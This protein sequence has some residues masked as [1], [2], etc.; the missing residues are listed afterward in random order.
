MVEPGVDRTDG[1]RWIGP[2]PGGVPLP[3]T[4]PGAE[5]PAVTL[6]RHEARRLRYFRDL[7]A[8]GYRHALAPDPQSRS[9]R[10]E[11]I[12][13]GIDLP[14]L[15]TVPLWSARRS[16]GLVS[17]PFIEFIL[18]QICAIL[19]A[20][21]AEPQLTEHETGEDLAAVRRA[22]GAILE[23]ASPGSAAPP[24]LPR[25]GDIYVSQALLENLCAPDGLLDQIVRRCERCLT[26][27][28]QASGL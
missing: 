21:C 12:A 10:A 6:A 2:P 24:A 3:G 1:Y 5:G 15:D 9:L 19:D 8:A 17:I 26:A 18:A 20:F 28:P 25:L 27:G 11:R 23:R 14:E 7:L 13:L 22:L 4:E 16:D